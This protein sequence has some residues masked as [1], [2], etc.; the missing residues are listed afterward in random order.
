MQTATNPETG[1]TMVLVDNQWSKADRVATND[2]G[3]K[4]YLVSGKWLTSQGQANLPS[5][6]RQQR[7]LASEAGRQFIG[8]PLR[9]AIEGAAALP[10]MGANAVAGLFNTISGDGGYKFPDQQAAVSGLLTRLGFPVPENGLERVGQDVM[11]AVSGAGL[12][13]K[14]AQMASP[15][16]GVGQIV[17]RGFSEN[18]PSQI[19]AAAGAAGASGVTREAGGGPL[20]QITAGLAGGVGL[21]MAVD[22]F[23]SIP[24]RMVARSLR[25]S[26]E[27]AFGKEGER[28]A[29][30]TGIPM[31]AGARSGNKLVLGMENTARQYGPTADQVQQTDVRIA[32]AAIDRVNK[33]ADDIVKQKSDPATLGKKIED[34]VKNSVTY[35]DNLRDTT[36]KADYG[37]VR[38]IAGNQPVIRFDNFV[39]ELRKIID[40]NVNVAGA[41]AQKVV[42]QARAALAKVTEGGGDGVRKITTP[43]GKTI[44]LYG[45]PTPSTIEG[46]I[47]DA[48]RS[49][50]FYGKAA[51]GGAN[52]FDDIAP[53]LNRN[54]ASRLFGAITRD[55]D[56]S[57]EVSS[58]A[59]KEAFSR[60][61]QNYKQFSQS[62][63]YIQKSTLGKLVGDD[64][65]D[66]A[67]SG[68][69]ITTKSGEEILRKV[70]G[71][72]PSIRQQVM[73][74]LGRFNPELTKE[75]RANVLRD[76][77][78]K[79][80]SIPPSA[81]GAGQV[82]ISF[83]KFITAI[84]GEKG[85]FETQ[86]KSYGF[87]SKEIVDIKDTVAAMMRS[88]D[89]T[90][91]NFSNTNVQ[92]Q[93]MEF[94][95]AMG[96]A[97]M[98]NVRGAISKVVS[99]GGKFIGA[100]K[101]ADAMA[102]AEGRA[103]LRTVANPKASPQA[104]AA[105]FATLEQ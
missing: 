76:A 99:I 65:V 67:I 62:L 37:K 94:A 34:T 36:A 59:L 64:L 72:D 101:F 41:D 57:A 20:A 5:P 74:D 61:N 26:E 18:L 52:V 63:E 30:A 105:A 102:S 4:A 100:K 19:G 95:G 50:S 43:T 68:A 82:P 38:E 10:A 90:G 55:F 47:D 35:L 29:E 81:K 9:A 54:I 49:R 39:S 25:K 69:R 44:K 75:I 98:G 7:S 80:M 21:P 48:M 103:A 83:N 93:A 71:A 14:L 96:D 1:E 86:L 97:A 104:I 6:E 24:S 92:N 84:G 88:G 3:E 46:T 53:D 17:A 73:T 2:K 13:G 45:D 85:S 15:T 40:E 78:E 91:Y 77:L 16:S 11:G 79:G 87:N 22:A 58:G 51:R 42:A 89:R 28:L 56:S 23:T 8:L 31:T 33:L 32:N 66:A 27:S 70:M 60:A 12:T